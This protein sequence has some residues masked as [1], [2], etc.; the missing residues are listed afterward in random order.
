MFCFKEM[1]MV[2]MNKMSESEQGM[3]IALAASQTNTELV[4]ITPDAQEI[5]AKL[6]RVSNPANENNIKTAP[7]LLQYLV[8]HHHW[9]PFEMASMCV[10][11]HTTRAIAAQILRHRS[12]SFQELSQRFASV[13]D[14]EYEIPYFR[15]QDHKN[16]QSSL[17]TID[18]Q[19][20]QQ[21]QTQTK[22]VLD[23]CF[24]LY[25]TL[26]DE[27][28]AKECAR[29]VLPLCTRTRMYMTGTIRSWI[30]YIQL[31]SAWDTQVEHRV[32]AEKAKAL[33]LTHMPWIADVLQ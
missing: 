25:N 1:D 6:A 24:Q 3:D 32:I 29:M 8:A 7:K 30:H 9:S 21:L 10:E 17:D 15:I 23:Q 22:A 33:L 13:S 31:R 4:W 28:V 2:C 26:L 16:R 11:I 18:E 12:F 5:I 27:G 19:K 14:M 20:Q